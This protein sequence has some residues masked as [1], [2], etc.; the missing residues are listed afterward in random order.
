[1][2]GAGGPPAHSPGGGGKGGGKH[3]GGGRG[4]AIDFGDID[5]S[6]NRRG[7]RS[8]VKG[9]KEREASPERMDYEDDPDRSPALNLIRKD[10]AKSKMRLSE[11]LP[12]IIE[13][14][15]DQHGSRFLQGK[16]DEAD[17]DEK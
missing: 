11:A 2:P 8:K 5:A 17:R 14:A 12:H 1:M 15:R 16:L 7:R 10:G 3:K 13:F 6:R 4:G 9:A